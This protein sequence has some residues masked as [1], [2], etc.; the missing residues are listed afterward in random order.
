[1][2]SSLYVARPIVLERGFVDGPGA[3]YQDNYRPPMHIQLND[4]TVI[5][6]Y[7]MKLHEELYLEN[8]HLE[9]VM[10]GVND[11]FSIREMAATKMAWSASRDDNGGFK[12]NGVRIMLDPMRDAGAPVA[13]FGESD[14][15]KV[16][17][18]RR[19]S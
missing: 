16:M 6:D 10:F 3:S 2:R 8:I 12:I 14:A 5:L 19:K 11:Y 7:L 1:M 15:I 18:M 13:V 4:P 17:S 9:G